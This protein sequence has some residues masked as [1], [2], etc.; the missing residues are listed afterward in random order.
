MYDFLHILLPNLKQKI[1]SRCILLDVKA[2]SI[3]QYLPIS[4]N[5]TKIVVY[6]G[7]KHVSLFQRHGNK[8]EKIKGKRKRPFQII[9]YLNPLQ[10]RYCCKIINE[11]ITKIF[12]QSLTKANVILK[13]EGT[14]ES[15]RT[16]SFSYSGYIGFAKSFED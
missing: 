3:Y 5:L 4:S 15:E 12:Q 9:V 10:T 16:K 1:I 2:L 6:E 13:N 7:T 8:I 11:L 14:D